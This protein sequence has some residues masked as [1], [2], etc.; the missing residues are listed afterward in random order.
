M[1]ALTVL[2]AIVLVLGLT[3]VFYAGHSAGTVIQR[4]VIA[5]VGFI[6]IVAALLFAGHF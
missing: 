4:T 5:L 3:V 6:L 1:T 2:L